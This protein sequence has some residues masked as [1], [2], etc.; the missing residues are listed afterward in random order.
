M[1]TVYAPTPK[2]TAG[3][4]EIYPLNPENR[5]QA[6]AAATYKSVSTAIWVA[7]SFVMTSGK[8]SPAS[9][10]TAATIGPVVARARPFRPARPGLEVIAPSPH[11][12]RTGPGAG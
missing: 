3:P 2:N 8:I 9:S 6:T 7:V 12:A 4:S 10:R 1:P 5:F 11:A